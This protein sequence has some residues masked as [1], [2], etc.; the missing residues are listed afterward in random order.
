MAE[1]EIA[2]W[3]SRSGEQDAR[4]IERMVAVDAEAVPGVRAVATPGH[5]P[6]TTSL[7][8]EWRGRT[9]AVVGDTV[10]TEAHFSA[11]RAADWDPFTPSGRRSAIAIIPPR[12]RAWAH[13]P[14]YGAQLWRRQQREHLRRG[15]RWSSSIG[16][17]R[18]EVSLE[19]RRRCRLAEL[20]W[21]EE[22]DRNA[23]LVEGF[24]PPTDFANLPRL[25]AGI[26]RVEDEE[27]AS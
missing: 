26:Y 10:M 18:D 19:G 17:A 3:R 11:N 5:T 14:R 20:R 27:A 21:P 15:A 1:A 13:L 9:I 23:D 6:G 25:T 4:L 12:P 16:D 8:F 2:Y 7:L 24:R 22:V